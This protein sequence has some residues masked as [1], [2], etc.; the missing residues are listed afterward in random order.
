MLSTYKIPFSETDWSVINNR[1][2]VRRLKK[3]QFDD[4][5][6]YQ[7]VLC[8][9]IYVSFKYIYLHKSIVICRNF[10]VRLDFLESHETIEL[11][12]SLPKKEMRMPYTRRKTLRKERLRTSGRATQYRHPPTLNKDWTIRASSLDARPCSGTCWKLTR[13]RACRLY[14]I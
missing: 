7:N 1:C 10:K 6:L 11:Q 4:V 3:E 14:A 8:I 12:A 2:A 5:L 9:H 13:V